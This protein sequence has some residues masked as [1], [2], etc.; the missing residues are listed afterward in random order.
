MTFKIALRNVFRNK[1]RTLFSLGVVALGV[2]ILS[3]VLG[4]V[5]ASISSTKTQLAREIGAFQVANGAL[6][7]DTAEGFD[8]LIPPDTLERVVALLNA[9]A[10]VT[11]YTT[12]ISFGGIIGNEK[13][14]TLL[15][16]RGLIPGNPVEDY[17]SLIDEGQPLDD[18]GTPQIIVGRKLANTLGVVPGDWI[19]IA[20]GTVSGAFRAVSARI[21]GTFSYNDLRME[22]QL[23][24]VPLSFAQKIM[25][26]QGVDRVIVQIEDL[27]EAGAVASSIKARLA[28]QGIPLETRTWQALTTFYKSITQFW[29]V[30]S[31]FMVLGVS[32]LAFFSVLEVLTMAFLERTREM[33]TIRA[34]GTKRHQVFQTLLLEGVVLGVMGGAVGAALGFVLSL[35]INASG[36]GW[37]PPGAIDP[38]PLHIEVSGSA[39]G[40]PFMIAVVSTFLGTLYPALSNARKNIVQSLSYV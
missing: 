33:G 7:D 4:F 21:K 37:L 8:Y 2:A 19:N 13:G 34:L 25:K 1:R 26:T 17:S 3:L 31:G 9:D 20:T 12:Q 40:V 16:A 5:A 22:G 32:V 27:D 38:V 14:S 24:F 6:F 39:L 10:R 11:G 35:A 15:V 36:A 30:F 23:G 28:S 18:D 29:G